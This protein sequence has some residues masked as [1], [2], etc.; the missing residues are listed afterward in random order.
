MDGRRLRRVTRVD[1]CAGVAWT[2][3]TNP[4]GTVQ[5]DRERQCAVE[6]KI[7]G[8]FKVSEIAP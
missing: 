5:I 3:A 6:R 7:Y 4:D 8:P 2:H 1:T